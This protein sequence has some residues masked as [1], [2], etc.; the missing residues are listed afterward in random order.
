MSV[1]GDYTLHIG[2]DQVC[3]LLSAWGHR[4]SRVLLQL[5]TVFEKP[6][7]IFSFHDMLS[8]SKCRLHV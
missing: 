1:N 4:Y 5:T 2:R 8:E 3:F 7:D 6:M